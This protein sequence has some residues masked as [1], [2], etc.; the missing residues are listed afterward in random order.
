MFVLTTIT[1]H[2][3]SYCNQVDENDNIKKVYKRNSTYLAAHNNNKKIFF[4]L[5]LICLF[6]KDLFNVFHYNLNVPNLPRVRCTGPWHG[7]RVKH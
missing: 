4:S 1:G 3:A 5:L 2:M 7:T 6:L